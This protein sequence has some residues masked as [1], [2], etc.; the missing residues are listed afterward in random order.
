MI[1]IP[2]SLVSAKSARPK[3]MSK[4]PSDQKTRGYSTVIQDNDK[5]GSDSQRE[6][7]DFTPAENLAPNI[8]ALGMSRLHPM[9]SIS[10]ESPRRILLSLSPPPHA[11][12][13]VRVVLFCGLRP[14]S[15]SKAHDSATRPLPAVCLASGAAPFLGSVQAGAV[16]LGRQMTRCPWLFLPSL[17]QHLPQ[18][19]PGFSAGSWSWS[20][21]PLWEHRLWHISL[22]GPKTL[23]GVGV[24]FWGGWQRFGIG[25]CQRHLWWKGVLREEGFCD[26]S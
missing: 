21:Q 2:D 5:L 7:T 11:I 13:K 10:K 3:K 24:L 18:E 4:T 14:S 25:Q 6:Q 19:S 8:F 1:H 20:W 9:T 16:Y 22:L 26:G 23:L 12:D 15:R 17:L